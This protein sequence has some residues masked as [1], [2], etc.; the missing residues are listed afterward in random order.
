MHEFEAAAKPR[1]VVVAT[2]IRPYPA[3][4]ALAL[5]IVLYGALPIYDR[6]R[7]LGY[8]FPRLARPRTSNF[9]LKEAQS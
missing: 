8:A 9:I 1:K 7:S 4:L 6:L 2:D 3:G 5:L